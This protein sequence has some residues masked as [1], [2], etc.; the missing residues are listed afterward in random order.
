MRK[1]LS[2]YYSTRSNFNMVDS[3]MDI[4]QRAYLIDKNVRVYDPH[5]N[6]NVF[7]SVHSPN[8]L[9][10]IT[11]SESEI[12]F[13]KKTIDKELKHVARVLSIFDFKES[14]IYIMILE[15]LEE[16]PEVISELYKSSIQPHISSQV[17][18][19][20]SKKLN[21]KHIDKL[22]IDIHNSYPYIGSEEARDIIYWFK[23]MNKYC[24]RFLYHLSYQNGG[25][26]S[27]NIVKAM[28]QIYNIDSSFFNDI[29]YGLYEL[30]YNKISI[31]DIAIYNILYDPKN[32]SYKLFD[33]H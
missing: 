12:E 17:Q 20:V 13:A 30:Y 10:K 11:S 8:K 3:T 16:V 26:F 22:I 1:K 2:S 4:L 23:N 27:P 31:S 24:F 7:T 32:K 21:Q 25:V 33:C 28:H 9:V 19:L 18:T 29:S 15:R 6:N 5:R 14:P